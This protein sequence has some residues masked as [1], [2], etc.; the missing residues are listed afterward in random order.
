[1]AIYW[2]VNKFR[3]TVLRGVDFMPHKIFSGLYVNK[4]VQNQNI[5]LKIRTSN[6]TLN[7]CFWKMVLQFYL[8]RDFVNS[9]I[10]L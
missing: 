6:N 4:K 2:A 5:I 3:N 10:M 8:C 7:K 9:D 1:M